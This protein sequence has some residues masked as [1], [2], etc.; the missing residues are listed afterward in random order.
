MLYKIS[1]AAEG[2]FRAGRLII[3][4]SFAFTGILIPIIQYETVGYW[5]P[6]I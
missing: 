1:K 2:S 3:T 6:I 5:I 4:F